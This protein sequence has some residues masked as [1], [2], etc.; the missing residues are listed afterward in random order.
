MDDYI[1][2]IQI[3]ATTIKSES[4][5]VAYEKH[6]SNSKINN[7]KI[8]HICYGVMRNYYSLDFILAKLIKQKISKQQLAIILLIGI[9]ELRHTKKPHYSVVHEIVNLVAKI[10]KVPQLTSFTNGVLRSYLRQ[11]DTLEIDVSNNE[12]SKYNYPLWLLNKI[13]YH[14]PNNYRD[15]L[16]D[17]NN[18]PK[19]SLRI[20]P[21]KTTMNDYIVTL[22]QQQIGFELY[23]NYIVLN[24]NINITDI[25][26]FSDGFVSIQ[27]IHA[28]YL[29]KILPPLT[30]K[31]YILDAC[32]APGGKMCAILENY[33]VQLLGCDISS[34]RLMKV[35]QSLERLSLNAKI[36]K[37]DMTT[38]SWWN[39]RNFDIIIADVPC[40]ASGTLK[41]NPDI[42]L[43]LSEQDMATIVNTQRKI[44][45]NLSSMLVNGGYLL[46]ITCSILP[47]ENQYNINWYLEHNNNYKLV[48]QVNLLPNMYADGFYYAL[49]HK[50]A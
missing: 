20:N 24:S 16:L 9:Y 12:S 47:E 31:N 13:K 8:K 42:K 6:S 14:Y 41:R 44:L 36:L 21:Q 46:Y 30:T 50:S 43:H 22:Q 2:I 19:L 10:Y 29:L 26:Y 34:K 3:L 35:Q 39:K 49:L 5:K 18:I 33:N 40:S 38:N 28:Q 17:A 45:T 32:C 15:I 25:P 11:H 27:D 4:L 1:V 37:A 7:A 23:N 48:K